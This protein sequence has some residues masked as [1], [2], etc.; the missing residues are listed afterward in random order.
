VVVILMGTAGSRHTAIGRALAETL[1]WPLV[2]AHAPDAL[3]IA[4]AR[5]LGRR[6]HLV[7]TSAPLSPGDQD[8]VR[9]G[10]LGVRFVDLADRRDDAEE[11]I[12]AIRREFGL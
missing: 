12:A 10:L 1:G 6:E 9:G 11:I 7:A 3:H 8:T 4:V 5:V 2:D